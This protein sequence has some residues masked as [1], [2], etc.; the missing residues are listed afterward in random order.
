MLHVWFNEFISTKTNKEGLWFFLW[1][2]HIWIARWLTDWMS[3]NYECFLPFIHHLNNP[4]SSRASVQTKEFLHRMNNGNWLWLF[5]V[6]PALCI[7]F[8]KASTKNDG[9]INSILE[10]RN[11]NN[12][13]SLLTSYIVDSSH[14]NRENGLYG[15]WFIHNHQ[16]EWRSQR[17]K[18]SFRAKK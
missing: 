15:N 18:I 2:N 13:P 4:L 3:V 14:E 6:L 1:W 5:V 7:I 8:I 10:A 12:I 17:R 11:P 9:R 16:H